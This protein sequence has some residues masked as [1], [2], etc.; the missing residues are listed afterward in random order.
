M[1]KSVCTGL[2][3]ATAAFGE[4][5]YTAESA[6]VMWKA[7]K[8]YEKAGVGGSFD[9]SRLSSKTA[10][11][12]DAL[13]SSSRISIHSNS[14]NTNNPGRDATL[15]ESFFKVQ[16]AAVID[17]AVVSAKEGK[18]LVAITLNGTSRTIPM[19]YTLEKEKIIGKG[20]ID[21]A[22]FGLLPSLGAI[23]KA[24]YDL[25]EGKTWQDVEIGFEIATKS[26]CRR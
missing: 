15:V 19:H 8:T 7:F 6:K 3:I 13:L 21:L 10:T 25:H 14:V 17:A 12:I 5:T 1:L 23:N 26:E 4:C 9:Q 20:V 18:A 24:C 16:N 22:D 2:M 11:S